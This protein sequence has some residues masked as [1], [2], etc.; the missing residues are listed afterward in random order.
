M[1]TTP[2]CAI[3][4]ALL[5]TAGLMGAAAGSGLVALAADREAALAGS[6]PE[7]V[8]VTVGHPGNLP[9]STGLGMVAETFQIMRHEVMCGQY[10]EFLNAVAASD[11]HGLW[12]IA[13]GNA[14]ATETDPP[15]ARIGDDRVPQVMIDRIG[16]D[17][18]Y[19]YRVAPGME[20]MPIV[21][22]SFL[23]ALRFANW[24]HHAAASEALANGGS[25]ATAAAD[26]TETGA[27]DI[28]SAGAEAVRTAAARC[29]VPS[30]DEWYKAA[31]HQPE[32]DGGPPGSYWLYPTRSQEPP[33]FRPAGDADPGSANFL[34]EAASGRSPEDIGRRPR[35]QFV[36]LFPVGSFPEA[37]SFYGTLD[38]GGNAWEWTDSVVFATQRV[39]RGG[40]MAHRVVK[41][42]ATVRSNAAPTRQYLD[43]GFRLA[44]R[45]P[46]ATGG[47]E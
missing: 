19:R 3:G 28:A 36:H 1:N 46:P 11:P 33:L 18:A 14:L 27:Y 4:Y 7:A 45:V 29:W 47:V 9:D 22:V 13:M 40:S 44:R 31:Y 38:Q 41:L 5:F 21:N 37:A 6:V 17:G 15:L 12:D 16:A 34:D 20:Q 43:T 30:E 39:L 10:A 24:M 8:W 32:N 42:R 35:S 25:D 2:R 26:V 23:D